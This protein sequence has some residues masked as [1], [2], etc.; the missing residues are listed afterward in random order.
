[1]IASK[2]K[3]LVWKGNDRAIATFK[4]MQDIENGKAE[5]IEIVADW[6]SATR[7]NN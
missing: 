2:S 1:M 4:N 3:L 6:I 5:L 7:L